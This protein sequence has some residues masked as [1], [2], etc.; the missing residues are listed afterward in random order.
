VRRLVGRL[1]ATARRHLRLHSL[2]TSQTTPMPRIQNLQVSAARMPRTHS[3]VVVGNK[4][5]A[6]SALQP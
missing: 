1:T 4:K 5:L 3:R 6:E 2:A